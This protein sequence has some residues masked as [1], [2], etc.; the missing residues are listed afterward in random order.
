MTSSCRPVRSHVPFPLFCVS[1]ALHA[2]MRMHD[3]H[4]CFAGAHTHSQSAEQTL[5]ALARPVGP[6]VDTE[7]AG[8]CQRKEGSKREQAPPA[9]TA[10]QPWSDK[11]FSDLGSAAWQWRPP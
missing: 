11:L 9:P 10:A 7:G 5:E 8:C 6:H 1:M 4:C 2:L 3:G